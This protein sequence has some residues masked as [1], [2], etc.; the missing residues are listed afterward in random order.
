MTFIYL[1]QA[2]LVMLCLTH[3]TPVANKY[4]IAFSVRI[5]NDKTDMIELFNKQNKGWYGN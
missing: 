3:L 1:F 4:N 2:I 5:I